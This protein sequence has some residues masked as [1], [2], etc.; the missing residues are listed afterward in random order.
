MSPIRGWQL[1]RSPHTDPLAS[2]DFEPYAIIFPPLKP[3]CFRTSL[4][5][6]GRATEST[7]FRGS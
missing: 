7:V 3:G 6:F 1:I 4:L 2:F 5:F